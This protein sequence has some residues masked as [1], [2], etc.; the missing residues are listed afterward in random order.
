MRN[1]VIDASV[2][3]KWYITEEDSD[4]AIQIRDLH[5]AGKIVLSSPLIVIYEIGNVLTKHPSFTS[6]SS[7]SAFQSLLNLG[8][9]L[10]SFA[11]TKLLGKS[12]EISKQL[13][14]TFYDAMYVALTKEHDATLITA[15][16]DLLIKARQYCATQLLRETKPE[17]ISA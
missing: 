3:A 15:D 1:M 14:V 17:K 16:R 10:R 5:S 11:D 6:D 4:K 12:F 8:I 2:V 7:A 9:E 13:K